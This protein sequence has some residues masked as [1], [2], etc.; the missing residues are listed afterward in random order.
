MKYHGP[1]TSPS[2]RRGR[3]TEDIQA[4]LL[5]ADAGLEHRLHAALAQRQP[6]VSAGIARLDA[7]DGDL[8][9]QPKAPAGLHPREM[10]VLRPALQAVREV[11]TAFDRRR[12][13][14]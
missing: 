13:A 10:L 1:G 6:D 3:L 9:G 12:R 5:L 8:P 4:D 11:A 14:S 2:R 7:V